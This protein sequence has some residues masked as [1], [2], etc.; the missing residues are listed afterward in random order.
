MCV[1]GVVTTTL[2]GDVTHHQL[3]VLGEDIRKYLSLSN[4]L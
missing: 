2:F 4:V 1:F 3:D